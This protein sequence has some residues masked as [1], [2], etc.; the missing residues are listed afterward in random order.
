MVGGEKMRKEKRKKIEKKIMKICR[1][2]IKDCAKCPFSMVEK[3][4]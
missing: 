3:K 4:G 2:E 1:K